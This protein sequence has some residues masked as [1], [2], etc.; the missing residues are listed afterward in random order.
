[1]KTVSSTLTAAALWIAL[2]IAAVAQNPP[3]NGQPPHPPTYV[4]PPPEQQPRPT[5]PSSTTV[6]EWVA[7]GFVGSNFANNASPASVEGGGTVA[8]LWKQK[9]GAEFEA[10]FTP[11][12]QLQ[13][14]FFGLGVKPEVNSYMANAMWSMPYSAGRIQPFV[15]GGIGAIELRSGLGTTGSGIT[16]ASPNDSRFGGDIGAGLMSFAGNWGFKADVRYYRAS[17]VYN[18]TSSSTTTASASATSPTPPPPGGYGS[19]TSA[20][21]PAATLA[22]I[23]DPSATQSIASAA[24]SGLHF[25][26][27]NVG[28][29]VRW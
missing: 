22:S 25:W 17:G 7:S 16:T 9:L 1:M 19:T 21:A 2:P 5:S 15:S 28:L 11:N 6:N 4:Q 12:F 10:G 3:T 24:L 29:A 18:T 14:N 13:N 26:R 20:T 23:V 27:A 8:Y